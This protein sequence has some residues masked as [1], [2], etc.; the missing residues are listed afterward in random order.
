MAQKKNRQ[1]QLQKKAAKRKERQKELARQRAASVTPS[2]SKAKDW[3]LLKVFVTDTWADPMTLT[4]I[5]VVRQ[6][7]NNF[8]GMAVVLVDQACLGAKNA[9]GRVVDEG[10]Y[11]STYSQIARHQTLIE[12]DIDLAAKIIREGVDYA[13]QFGL[14]PNKDLPQALSL[15]QDADPDACMKTVPLGDDEGKP[16]FVA[17]PYDNVDAIVAKLTAAVGPD[18]FHYIIPMDP[19]GFMDE[20]D[21]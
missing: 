18:G 13:A 3:P 15:M 16:Y 2:L 17:G 8:F 1:K 19:S 20:T 6:G 11:R 7:P 21:F 14:R 5:M 4:Q 12:T 10:G 9:Y